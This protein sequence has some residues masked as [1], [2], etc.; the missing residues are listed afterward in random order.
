MIEGFPTETAPLNYEE[1]KLV[2]QFVNGLKTK[3]G[4]DKAVSNSQ[5]RKGFKSVGITVSDARVRKIINHIRTNAIVP[6]LCSNSK[7]YYVARTKDEVESYLRGLKQR[8]QA[9]QQV[10][11]QI[12]QQ[13][14]DIKT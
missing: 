7:G 6:L 1:L 3:I 10:Y 9:Q 2:P 5:I 13:Y 4:K 14:K 12:N 11:D 8:I